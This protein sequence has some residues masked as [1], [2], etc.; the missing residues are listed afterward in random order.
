MV[1]EAGP[2]LFV[3]QG[4]GNIVA[5]NAMSVTFD[6]SALGPVPQPMTPREAALHVWYR[7][8][9]SHLVVDWQDRGGRLAT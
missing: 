8:L 6:A 2:E 7:E 1:G 9:L 3:P 5:N 4:A